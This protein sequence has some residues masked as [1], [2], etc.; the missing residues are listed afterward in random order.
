[1]IVVIYLGVV[2]DMKS[3]RALADIGGGPKDFFGT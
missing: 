1:M 2:I 3:N